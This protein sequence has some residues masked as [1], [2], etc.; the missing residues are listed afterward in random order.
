MGSG[1]VPEGLQ[2]SKLGALM[3]Y[4]D[5]KDSLKYLMGMYDVEIYKKCCKCG[6]DRYDHEDQAY[7]KN[8]HPFFENNL[9]ML[10]WESERKEKELAVA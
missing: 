6:V 1:G 2:A 10:E 3:G 4:F 9:E 7:S 8:M 5:E